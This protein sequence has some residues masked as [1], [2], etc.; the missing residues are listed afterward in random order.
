M[1]SALSRQIKQSDISLCDVY[2][3]NTYVNTVTCAGLRDIF[4]RRFRHEASNPET[5]P[6]TRININ[7]TFFGARSMVAGKK[8]TDTRNNRAR[9]EVC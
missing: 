1:N 9:V 2:K 8:E 4:A 7:L 6:F 5:K 3:E